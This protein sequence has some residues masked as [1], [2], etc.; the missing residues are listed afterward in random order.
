MPQL[1]NTD[2]MFEATALAQN[3]REGK[4]FV[5]ALGNKFVGLIVLQDIPVLLLTITSLFV[6]CQS[7]IP[8]K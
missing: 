1:Y 4:R 3:R 5:Y 7:D 8:T 6:E 2:N